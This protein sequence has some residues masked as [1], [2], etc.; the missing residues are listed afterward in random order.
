M[1]G[2][3]IPASLIESHVPGKPMWTIK[4]QEI[5]VFHLRETRSKN[6]IGVFV[7]TSNP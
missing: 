1:E 4:S 2:T 3:G 6:F 7:P 5:I